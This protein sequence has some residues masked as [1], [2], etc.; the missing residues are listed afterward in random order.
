MQ[1]EKRENLPVCVCVCVRI[2]TQGRRKGLRTEGGRK[3]CERDESS[4]EGGWRE[5]DGS[6]RVK[7]RGERKR[8]SANRYRDEM[9]RDEVRKNGEEKREKGGGKD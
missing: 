6:E 8:E 9:T 3:S 1:K 4:E 5:V 2:C 7:W